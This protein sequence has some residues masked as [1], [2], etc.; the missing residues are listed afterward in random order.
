[1]KI[2]NLLKTGVFDFD[3]KAFYLKLKKECNIF[4]RNKAI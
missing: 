3:Y 1:M 4:V 2:R